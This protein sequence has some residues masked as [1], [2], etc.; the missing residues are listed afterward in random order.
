MIG[1]IRPQDKVMAMDW[2]TIWPYF[3]R[4]LIAHLGAPS[5]F[6]DLGGL[7]GLYASRQMSIAALPSLH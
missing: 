4:F 1:Q 2:S 6:D 3:L 7:H 5:N